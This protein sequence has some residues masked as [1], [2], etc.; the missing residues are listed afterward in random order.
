M[1]Q[2]QHTSKQFDADLEHIRRKVLAMGGLVEH[3]ITTAIEAFRRNDLLLINRVIED[4]NGIN[5]LEREIDGLCAAVIAR[6]M[7]AAID[8]RFV[9]VS[10]KMI[11]DLER[12]GD[13]AKKIAL[14]SRRVGDSG[15]F[16][17]SRYTELKHLSL[18]VTRML[19]HALDSFARLDA[20]E[21]MENVRRDDEVD[22][23]FHAL[24]RQLLTYMIEDP[25]TISSSLDVIFIAKA[26]ERIGDHAKNIS[27][28]VIYLIKGTDVRHVT[29]E[30]M[31]EV[32]RS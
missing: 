15:R 19:R 26:L 4:D 27:E 24:L 25:R 29:M 30:R 22:E 14:Y 11:T 6:R 12:I 5:G 23:L 8:L 17:V 3:Q 13:E 18:L 1:E 16:M 7:P 2:T 21:V 28:Y 31:E 9:L 10:L 20:G 32:A